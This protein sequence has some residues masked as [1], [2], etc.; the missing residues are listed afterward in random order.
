VRKLFLSLIMLTV[1]SYTLAAANPQKELVVRFY[2][3]REKTLDERGT[4]QDIDN[5]L[6]LMTHEARYEHPAASV[7]MTKAEV[8][9]GML[10]H[11]HEG[12]HARYT[13]RHARFTSDFAVVEFVLDYTV[14]GEKIAR[15]GV[16]MFEFRGDR[17]SRVSEY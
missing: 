7:T 9:S 6:A 14:N 11:L 17:I 10:A 13:L 1:S 5:L 4:A 3:L 16:A 2:E 8:R 12:N 15:P